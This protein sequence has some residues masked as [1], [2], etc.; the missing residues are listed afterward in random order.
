LMAAG[1]GAKGDVEPVGAV[2]G[3][4][5][6]GQ[7][8]QFLLGEL[9]ARLIVNLVRHLRVGSTNSERL[10][11]IVERRAGDMPSYQEPPQRERRRR[12]QSMMQPCPASTDLSPP[13]SP[14]HIDRQ[15]TAENSQPRDQI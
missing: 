14:R 1:N 12:Q 2:D 5:R 13:R 10:R 15:R 8:D 7:I 3:D 11:S 9:L 4:D 6:Q